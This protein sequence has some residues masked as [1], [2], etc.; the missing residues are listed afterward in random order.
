MAVLQRNSNAEVV[1][2]ALLFKNLHRAIVFVRYA[3]YS[4]TSMASGYLLMYSQP[5]F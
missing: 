1:S 3:I 2:P 5:P 4:I